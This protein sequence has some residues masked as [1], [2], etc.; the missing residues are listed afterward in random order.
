MLRETKKG[1]ATPN[2][3]LIGEEGIRFTSY[4]SGGVNYAA[5]RA[6]LTGCYPRIGLGGK[7][8]PPGAFVG[9]SRRN[10]RCR[11]CWTRRAM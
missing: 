2:I 8:I 1:F 11:G 4:Y 7:N 5:G 10:G 9:R 6:A 3:D